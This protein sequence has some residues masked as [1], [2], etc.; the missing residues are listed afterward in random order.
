MYVDLAPD[1]EFESHSNDQ[2]GK[3]EPFE[4]N[5]FL[6]T[7]ACNGHIINVIRVC[8]FFGWGGGG[9]TLSDL[10]KIDLHSISMDIN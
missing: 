4:N 5:N 6:F 10:G 7:P 9:V 2:I 3:Y 8:V 1:P